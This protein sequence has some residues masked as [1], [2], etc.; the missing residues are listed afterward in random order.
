M[1]WRVVLTLVLLAGAI[2]SG[3]SVWRKNAGHGVAGTSS[4]RS[5]YVLHDF[6]L[7]TLD[8]TTGKEAFT[9]RAP[10]LQRN[11]RGRTMSLTTPLFSVPDVAGHYWE[12][13]ALTGWVNGEGN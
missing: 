9:L 8:G 10:I 12:V 5:D 2:V 6:E 1:N 3:W 7:V 4:G 13:G 11:P